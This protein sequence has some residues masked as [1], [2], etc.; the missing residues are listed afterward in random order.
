LGQS[1]SSRL[2]GSSYVSYASSLGSS[3]G[4]PS[5]LLFGLSL[6]FGLCS[7]SARVHDH[8]RSANCRAIGLR[9]GHGTAARTAIGSATSCQVA[10]ERV[11]LHQVG[12]ERVGDADGFLEDES[13][14]GC[15]APGD[16][17]G[18]VRLE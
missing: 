16:A 7:L 13:D 12:R 5:A 10:H 8:L 2:G 4:A 6:L 9:D 1:L 18:V 11:L 3:F 14:C 15:R 17:E